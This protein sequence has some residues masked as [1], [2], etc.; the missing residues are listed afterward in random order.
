MFRIMLVARVYRLPFINFNSQAIHRV[1]VKFVDYVESWIF[2]VSETETERL[3]L[4]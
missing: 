1:N 2:L 4:M 3:K